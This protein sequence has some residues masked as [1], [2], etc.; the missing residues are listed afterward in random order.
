MFRETT[1]RRMGMPKAKPPRENFQIFPSWKGKRS[2]KLGM[3]LTKMEIRLEDLLKA[4][5]KSLPERLLELTAR[6]GTT[7]ERSLVGPNQYLKTRGS[8]PLP[9]H[10]RTFLMLSLT[11]QER[12]YTRASR[13]VF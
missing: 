13:L 5:P 9:R 6:F 2:T 10:L 8:L 1:F 7:P 3:S 4:T 12:L 11:N